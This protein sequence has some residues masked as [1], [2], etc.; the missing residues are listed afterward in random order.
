MQDENESSFV[1][2]FIPFHDLQSDDNSS[3]LI[4]SI[5]KNVDPVQMREGPHRHNYQELLWI[6]SGYGRHKI[7]ENILEIEANTFYF[8]AKGQVHYFIKGD[9]L[10]GYLIRFTDDF[11]QS[12]IL[13][14]RLNYQVNLFNHFAIHQGLTVEAEDLEAFENIMGR[15]QIEFNQNRFGKETMLC[16]LLCQLL[17]SLERVR[18]QTTHQRPLPS[19]N[20]EFYEKFV[21]LLEEKFNEEHQVSYYSHQ[22]G[23]TPRKLSDICRRFNGKTAKVMIRDRLVL[24]AKRY[25]H[26]TNASIKEISYALGFQDPS[27]FS[28]VFRVGT[29]VPPYEFKRPGGF[30]DL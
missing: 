19:K 21:V 29:G 6:K 5:L 25:L 23:V 30:F 14:P 3:F 7:D 8:V 10:E 11:L 16:H 22:L 2:D 20:A 18:Q 24:E 9:D 13:S 28:K 17:I 27:Y 4:R 26:F 12:N 1:D 15:M